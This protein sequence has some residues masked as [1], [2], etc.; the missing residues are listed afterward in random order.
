MCPGAKDPLGIG[1]EL[2]AAMHREIRGLL[3]HPDSFSP[4]R[5]ASHM[6]YGKERDDGSEY[7]S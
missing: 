1:Y 3:M 4:Q 7:L 5:T 2:E 6:V